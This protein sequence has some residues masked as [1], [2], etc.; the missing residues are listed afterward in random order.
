MREPISIVT[1]HQDFC[2]NVWGQ[3]GIDGQCTAAYSNLILNS[4]DPS[5]SATWDAPGWTVTS[6]ETPPFTGTDATEF[7]RTTGD[8]EILQVT[9]PPHDLFDG[10]R[11]HSIRIKSGSVNL[12]RFYMG[13]PINHPEEGA[14][15]AYVIVDLETGYT[16]E[17][18][19]VQSV[20][21]YDLEDDGWIYLTFGVPTEWL[22]AGNITLNFTRDGG[23][24]LTGDIGLISD[25]M[26]TDKNNQTY[27][28]TT[29]AS[30]NH[31]GNLPCF[32]T[33]KTCQTPAE[34]QPET[35]PLKFVSNRSP[36]LRD[37]YYIP[38]LESVR[39]GA[40][41]IN[42][43][44][45]NKSASALGQRATISVKFNDHPHNDRLVDPYRDQRDYDPFTRGSF[46]SKWRARNPFYMHRLLTFQ[47]GY[48]EGGAI[49]DSITRSFVITDFSGPDSDG[50]VEIRGKDLL[51][52]AENSKA[53]AP[54]VSTGK[55]LAAITNV[56]GTGTLTPAGIGNLEY[57]ASGH[58]RI[59]KEIIVFTRSADTLTFTTR[60]TKG[61]TAAA[62]SE[63]AN[64]QL[65]LVYD[66]QSPQDILFDLLTEYA[67]IGAY[68]LDTDQWDAETLDYLPRLYSAFIA[69]PE[70]VASL[71]GEMCEQMYFTV[72]FDERDNKIKIRAVRTAADDEI[73]TLNDNAHLLQD[74][75]SWRDLPDQI[76][77]QAWIYYGQINP[78]QK[79][80]EAANYAAVEVVANLEAEDPKQ[81][82]SQN[83]KKIFSRWIGVGSAAAAVDLGERIIRRYSNAPRECSFQLD[84]KDREIWLSSFVRLTNRLNVDVYGAP[85]AA[86]LQ[87]YQAEEMEVGTRFAYVAQEFIPPL[88]SEVVNTNARPLIISS[89][90]LN[91]NLREYYEREYGTPTGTEIVTLTIRSGVTIGGDTAGGGF[92][93]GASE[94]TASNDFYDA[95]NHHLTGQPFGT[96]QILQRQGITSP[97]TFDAGDTYPTGGIA[98]HEIREYQPSIAF[99]TGTWPAGSTLLMIIEPGVK[100]LGEGGSGSSHLLRIGSDTYAT[101]APAGD[102]GHAMLIEK[103]IS[104]DNRGTIAAGGGGGASISFFNPVT[105]PSGAHELCIGGGGGAGFTPSKISANSHL[106]SVSSSAISQTSTD[107]EAGIS[108]AGGLGGTFR[109]SSA[110]SNIYHN[111]NAR[112]GATMLNKKGLGGGLAQAGQPASYWYYSAYQ[113]TTG[114]LGTYRHNNAFGIAGHAITDGT[115][116]ITWINKGDVRGAEY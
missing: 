57:P 98:L 5:D 91:V 44:G 33:R 87:V 17:T 20:D 61:T 115:E 39:I 113:D 90:M 7:V 78:T 27:L 19:L 89:D 77:T 40:A 8:D 81:N 49:T 104:I 10:V 12:V 29:G 106:F 62:H 38:S 100:I 21:C 109:R 92:N 2:E 110:A 93:V 103:A 105:H 42:P 16:H 74:S 65:C 116:L 53:Q 14:D 31:I 80:D 37:G 51:T 68:Y 11:Y 54:R 101:G 28:Q 56:S 108:D 71:V 36:Q 88:E 32:N 107:P 13:M 67:G 96:V 30:I 112:T 72:W 26:V 6:G 23:P 111:A 47:T 94:R 75:V 95:G 35:L 41:K 4:A 69:E 84:A 70:G 114:G 73:H 59:E 58:V 22:V 82:N 43:G 79:L 24:A 52:L 63:N 25:F 18:H 1:L 97:R 102:G 83:I 15:T 3:G 99:K 66:A 64:V 76:V 46:W 86:D 60:G 85:A 48:F 55:L 50:N 34:Y 9:P 45:A